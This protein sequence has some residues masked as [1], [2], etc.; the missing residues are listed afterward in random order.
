MHVAVGLWTRLGTCWLC[1]LLLLTSKTAEGMYKGKLARDKVGPEAT[2]NRDDNNESEPVT[3][4][5]VRISGKD[6]PPQYQLQ[7]ADL[8]AGV[9]VRTRIRCGD[10]PM[11]YS[12]FYG[13]WEFVYEKILFFF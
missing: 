10:R 9:E 3:V 8:L 6:I 4:A 5:W 7:P 1:M 12:L 11:G 13:V 2:P